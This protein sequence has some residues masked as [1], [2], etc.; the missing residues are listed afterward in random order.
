MR[1]GNYDTNAGQA[2]K[3]FVAQRKLILGLAVAA[4]LVAVT[5]SV[6]ENNRERWIDHLAIAGFPESANQWLQANFLNV[7]HGLVVL[8]PIVSAG[9]IAFTLKFNLG[10]NWIMLRSSAE[11]LKKEIYLYR[12]QV[13]EYSPVQAAIESRD[14]RLARKVKLIS[15]RLMETQVNQTILEPY[16]D[17][18][19]PAKATAEGDDGFSD[20]TPE[21][22]I[23]YRV[24]DQFRYYQGK[25]VRLGKELQRFQ[26]LVIVL[27]GIGT[28]LA[29]FGLDIWITVS[30]ALAT[31]FASYLEFKRVETT[32]VSCNTAAADLYD[33]RAW[34]R[35]L[36]DAAKTQQANIETL[37]GSTET[38]IQ[39]E[40][41][42]WVQEMREALAE[43]YGDKKED[44]TNSESSE[45]AG[46]PRELQPSVTL[47]QANGSPSEPS[48]P[49][50][51]SASP[52]QSNLFDDSAQSD[53]SH[54]SLPTD[55]ASAVVSDAP[56]QDAW[57]EQNSTKPQD[58]EPSIASIDSK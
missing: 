53:A 47:S 45:P 4:A 50:E 9:L 36:P 3:H 19:P 27:G 24:E 35:A 18:L 12:M 25:A 40:N 28:A 34:W 30:S 23:V 32:V 38:V 16:K 44:D 5:Y 41:A 11:A 22:Y 52:T 49:S 57:T 1:F 39:S 7:F 46:P 26:L 51:P 2:Q 13:G 37:V 10:V 55:V 29:A 6:L 15:K 21:Q 17:G 54:G 20:L 43:I 42:G 31:A 33:I 8:I 14:V 56:T 48:E 58:N